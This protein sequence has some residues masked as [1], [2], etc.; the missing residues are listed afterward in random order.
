MCKVKWE[1]L[2]LNGMPSN[3]DKCTIIIL[4]TYELMTWNSFTNNVLQS[5]AI[6][7]ENN[8]NKNGVSGKCISGSWHW[9]IIGGN[10]P[11]YSLQL[12]HPNFES[13]ISN[14]MNN[15]DLQTTEPMEW[16]ERWPNN[17]FNVNRHQQLEPNG[18]I[19]IKN[20]CDSEP[21]RVRISFRV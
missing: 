20:A 9:I 13:H 2:L 15:T 10:S 7:G 21:Q 18:K 11:L 8:N 12:Y 3:S 1:H 6:V 14:S 16:N 5:Y 19:R 4:K 17:N